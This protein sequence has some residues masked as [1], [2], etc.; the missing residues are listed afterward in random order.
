MGNGMDEPDFANL[1]TRK[2]T[3]DEILQREMDAVEAIRTGS[4]NLASTEFRGLSPADLNVVFGA[5]D[6]FFLA[7][8]T[9]LQLDR[10]GA[11]LGFRLATRMTHTGGTTTMTVSG[12]NRQREF[13]I[14][15]SPRVVFETFQAVDRAVVCGLECRSMRMALI[16]IMQHELIHLAEF[17]AWGDSSCSRVRF[18]SIARGL[19][20]HTE[21]RHRMLT[22]GERARVTHQIGPGDRVEFECEGRTWRGKVNRVNR[23]ATVLVADPGGQRY[24]DGQNYKKFYVPLNLLRRTGP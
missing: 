8:K 1:L 4:P 9:R 3:S 24:S 19:F 16:R 20:G 12:R 23:R 11:T 6:R 7:G 14:A 15:V 2:L 13:V 21:T 22:P 18:R 5:I 10:S 17:V